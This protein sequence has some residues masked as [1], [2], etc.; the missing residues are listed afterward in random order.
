MSFVKRLEPKNT[1]EIKPGLFIK[2]YSWG[3]RQVYPAS[4]NGKINW[5]NFITGGS[6]TKLLW[7]FIILFLVFAYL[8]D[9]SEYKKFYEEVAE[10]PSEYCAQVKL[11]ELEKKS[12]EENN[13]EKNLSSLIVMRGSEV[14]NE[15]TSNIPS[16]P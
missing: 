15:S 14:I 4:W 7:F 11:F 9:V 1:E 6:W 8:N 3:Y 10:N 12:R 16:Y 13:K 5:Y 2:K